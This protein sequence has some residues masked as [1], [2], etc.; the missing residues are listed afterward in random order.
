MKHSQFIICI[1]RH[2]KIE[3]SI[4]LLK[5]KI[6]LNQRKNEEKKYLHNQVEDFDSTYGMIANLATSLFFYFLS[7]ITSQYIGRYMGRSSR[8]CIS[9]KFFVLKFT[10]LSMR[11]NVNRK[12]ASHKLG[13]TKLGQFTGLFKSF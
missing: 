2:R 6:H 10:N 11:T 12:Q 7:I 9:N 8:N 3:N 1:K 5:I 4:T 13:L